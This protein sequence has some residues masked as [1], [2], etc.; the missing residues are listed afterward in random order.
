[1]T[2]KLIT[3]KSFTNQFIIEDSKQ[4]ESIINEGDTMRPSPQNIVTKIKKQIIFEDS[5][6]GFDKT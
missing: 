4:N 1:M 5:M 6:I 2:P 3:P